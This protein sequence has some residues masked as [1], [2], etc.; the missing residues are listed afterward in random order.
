MTLTGHGSVLIDCQTVSWNGGV[1]PTGCLVPAILCPIIAKRTSGGGGEGWG[2]LCVE[3]DIL[4][5]QRTTPYSVCIKQE[6]PGNETDTLASIPS[7][8]RLRLVP[9][10]QQWL[11]VVAPAQPAEL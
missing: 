11:I 8:H 3:G 10:R 6:V 9:F 4:V 2:L 7:K 1:P 5:T